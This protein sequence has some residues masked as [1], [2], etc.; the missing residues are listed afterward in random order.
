M[1]TPTAASQLTSAPVLTPTTQP[2]SAPTA[3]QPTSAPTSAPTVQQPT[4]EPTVQPAP[5][6]QPTTPVQI[7]LNPTSSQLTPSIDPC[8]GGAGATQQYSAAKSGHNHHHAPKDKGFMSWLLQI[9]QSFFDLIMQL[10]GINL[11]PTTQVAPTTQPINPTNSP[12]MPTPTAASQLTSAPV[13]TP[14]AQPTS[15]PTPLP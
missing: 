1:P 9:L 3:E 13:L 7:S 11:S 12:C 14:T 8:A 5:S 2:T 4:S 10:L 15:A 6:S